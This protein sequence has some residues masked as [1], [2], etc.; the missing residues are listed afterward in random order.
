M[1]NV[2]SVLPAGR[3][4][5]VALLVTAAAVTGL[6]SATTSTATATTGAVAT[7][8]P[9]LGSSRY[10]Q[11]VQ[12]WVN[13]RRSHHGLRTLRFATCAD[14]AAERWGQFLASTDSFFHQSMNAVLN[15]CDARY[16]GETLGRGAISPKRLV[17][18]WMHSPEHRHILLSRYP[19]RIGIGAYPNQRGEWVVAADFVRL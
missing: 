17:Y 9:A 16:A 3:R 1:M 14:R 7:A 18:L 13:V 11:R 10:E 15:R 12:Y 8:S 2:L 5:L 4:L 6:L 19:R